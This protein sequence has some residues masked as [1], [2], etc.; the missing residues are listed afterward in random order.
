MDL[1][2]LASTGATVFLGVAAWRSTSRNDRATALA[3][4]MSSAQQVTFGH[5]YD[6]NREL[7][8]TI[9]NGGAYPI[10]DVSMRAGELSVSGEPEHAEKDVLNPGEPLFLLVGNDFEHA[11]ETYCE[12][13]F[14]Y[15]DGS[16]W[17]IE[18]D[19]PARLIKEA[20]PRRL[21]RRG[22]A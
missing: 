14:V 6:I 18:D 22:G 11:H 15:Q 9:T 5:H 19:R 2:G 10:R 21:F 12:A 4:R 20:P 13:E 17:R 16:R 1:L 8:L 3:N 7:W